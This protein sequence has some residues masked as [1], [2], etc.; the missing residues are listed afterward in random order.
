MKRMSIAEQTLKKQIDTIREKEEILEGR[1]QHLIIEKESHRTIRM[2][3]QEEYNN[4]A[5]ARKKA[6]ERNKP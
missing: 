1:I 5:V 2:Q 4:L 6:S 3:L